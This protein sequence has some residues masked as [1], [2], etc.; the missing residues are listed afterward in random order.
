[1]YFYTYHSKREGRRWRQYYYS[2]CWRVGTHFLHTQSPWVVTGS[3]GS[4]MPQ[5]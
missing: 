5:G 3:H 1:M 4:D 2:R